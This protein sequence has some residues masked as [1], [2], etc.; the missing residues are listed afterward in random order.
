M[1]RRI[2]AGILLLIA[3]APAAAQTG[4]FEVGIGAGYTFSEGIDVDSGVI[5]GID[6]ESGVSYGVSF[7]AYVNRMLEVGFMMNQEA[8]NLVLD[9]GV[10]IFDDVDVDLDVNN[11]HGY[12]AYNLGYSNAPVRPFFLFGMGATHYVTGEVDG[13]EI[14]NETRFSTTWGGGVKYYPPSVDYLGLRFM[15]RWTPTYIT[16]DADGWW[17]DPYWGCTT[18]GDVEY[19]HQFEMSGAALLRF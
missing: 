19:S 15:G 9:G 17:C 12:V 14:D 16:T 7:G 11:Y 6:V 1:R 5:N 13:N 4:R 8:S 18:Y 3:A 2:I 10:G